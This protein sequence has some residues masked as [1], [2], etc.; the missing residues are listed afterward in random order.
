MR[1]IAEP[2]EPIILSDTIAAD[3]A[4][5]I[6]LLLER[7][8]TA[9]LGAGASGSASVKADGVWAPLDF[10]K[11]L[12][13]AYTPDWVPP[14]P[15]KYDRPAAEGGGGGGGEEAEDEES[16]IDAE[17]EEED[18]DDEWHMHAPSG[19]GAVEGAEEGFPDLFRGF[20]FRRE[21]SAFASQGSRDDKLTRSMSRRQSSKII[22][23]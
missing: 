11:V 7:D 18:S 12:A 10:E 5:F 1:K 6:M 21:T 17:T 3:T 16:G 20:T 23:T 15:Q 2:K 22:R 8:P 19:G 9:R 4:R 13:K 14:D